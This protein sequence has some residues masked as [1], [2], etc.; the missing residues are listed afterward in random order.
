MDYSLD[1][2]G[3][4]G[5]HIGT[6]MGFG[7]GGF[8]TTTYCEKKRVHRVSWFRKPSKVLRGESL[9]ISTRWDYFVS[10]IRN[11]SQHE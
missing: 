4:I 11:F 6:L 3:T 2:W 9:K 1:V 5:T 8:R 7:G 10:L